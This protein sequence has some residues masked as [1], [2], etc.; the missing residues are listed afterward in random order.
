MS[1]LGWSPFTY[2]ILSS[3]RCRAS[4]GV[5]RCGKCRRM[6]RVLES[7][8]AAECFSVAPVLVRDWAAR[9]AGEPPR[10]V[11][12]LPG[13]GTFLGGGTTSQS[14]PGTQESETRPNDAHEVESGTPSASLSAPVAAVLAR[15]RS[16]EP[17]SSLSSVAEA[18]TRQQE[19]S[20]PFR[21][22]CDAVAEGEPAAG[23]TDYWK[24]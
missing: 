19:Y 5:W 14:P 3:C 18:V 6:L 21:L 15:D 23:S 24:A 9:V 20:C 7:L 8:L 16:S 2:N 12:Q 13:A 17:A 4:I 11:A 10:L 22:V 1:T